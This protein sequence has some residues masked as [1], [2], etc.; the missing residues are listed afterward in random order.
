MSIQQIN[1]RDIEALDFPIEVKNYGFNMLSGKKAKI[2]DC[3]TGT[4]PELKRKLKLDADAFRGCTSEN[5]DEHIDIL[6]EKADIICDLGSV[7][8]VDNIVIRSYFSSSVNYTIGEFM[9]YAADTENELFNE[10]NMLAHER[11]GVAWHKGKRNNAD[12]VYDTVGTFRYLGIRI[13]KSNET[14]DVIRLGHVGVYNSIYTEGKKYI[15][16]NFPCNLLYSQEP[17]C[18]TDG[19]IY[20]S[21][22]AFEISGEHTFNFSLKEPKK[23][24]KLWT[25][26]YGEISVDAGENLTEESVYNIEYGRKVYIFR[27]SADKMIDKLAVTCRGNGSVEQIGAYAG[28][29][30]VNV[31]FED[32]II[33]DFIGVGAD[34]IPTALMAES[35]ASG[36]NEV[37]WELEKCRIE[38]VRPHVVRLW[39]QIDWLVSEYKDYINGDLDFESEKM[40]ALYKYLDI[41]KT[42][43]TEVEFNF[44]WKI[45]EPVQSWFSFENVMN[46]RASA[47]K[48]LEPFARAC[49]K[50]LY[51]LI[52]N[53]GY[54][55]IKYLTFF[56]ESNA[57]ESDSQ[58]WRYDFAVPDG[59]IAREYYSDMLKLCKQSLLKYGLDDLEIW[60][61]EL[62]AKFDVWAE[63][64]KERCED[65]V[66]R[67]TFHRYF[68][69][70]SDDEESLQTT[71][72]LFKS[73]TYYTDRPV[74]MTECGQ[75]YEDENYSFNM[76]HIQLFCD[77][78][79]S[80]VSGIFI[81][82]LSG[83]HL[84]QPSNFM[85]RNGIDMWDALQCRGGIENVR[86]SYY[87]LAML[88]RYIPNHC[89]AVKTVVEENISG[90]RSC[91]FKTDDGNI[92]VVIE[93]DRGLSGRCVHINFEQSINRKLYKHIYKRPCLRNGNALIPPVSGT[94]LAQNGINDVIDGDYQCIVYTT[95]PTVPQIAVCSNEIS[96]L[97]DEKVR[98][99]AAVIDGEGGI[100]WKISESTDNSFELFSA[101]GC[102]LLRANPDA[103]VG[104]MA[105]IEV[106]SRRYPQIKNVIIAKISQ[107]G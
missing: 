52:K 75:V 15:S 46:R 37:Y 5:V 35:I 31:D 47:P 43:G 59:I 6:C 38:K 25:V 100:D 106:I 49:G 16:E 13:L 54:S 28:N 8:A 53:R 81:W 36:Y 78:V 17:L 87:E 48:E 33:D 2:I 19:L 94:L 56:N 30:S 22:S 34:V 99:S 44:G 29:T 51:E 62:T 84:T 18:V 104:S 103:Q 60:G 45:A 92:T 20:S 68:V 76:N 63:C 67:F 80:G 14:D 72:G 70:S 74:V 64:A 50:V 11:G 91:A 65:I 55:N 90:Y 24:L 23:A 40:H 77:A 89:K 107:K 57:A 105:A 12:W 42:V 26:V 93:A 9:L 69:E 61:F 39:F 58:F 97:P 27:A 86:G 21:D 102:A 7:T 66:D 41:F 82:C 85:M 98:L 96:L 88:S 32:V 79:N 71:A 3:N 4:A 101:E 83:V 10:E 95:L 73:A 1:K